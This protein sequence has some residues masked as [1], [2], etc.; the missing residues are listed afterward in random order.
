MVVRLSKRLLV[1]ALQGSITRLVAANADAYQAGYWAAY[2]G[3]KDL[4]KR[5]IAELKEPRIRLG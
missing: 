4:S 2:L 5:R 1:S 3:Y